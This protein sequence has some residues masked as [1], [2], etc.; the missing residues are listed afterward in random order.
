MY[1]Q[2]LEMLA[3]VA[4]LSLLIILSLEFHRKRVLTTVH[5]EVIVEVI[6]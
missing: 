4:Y 1:S 6:S 2:L 3:C 5:V